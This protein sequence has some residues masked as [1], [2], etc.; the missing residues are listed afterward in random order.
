MKIVRKCPIC[1]AQPRIIPVQDYATGKIMGYYV[2]CQAGVD[3]KTHRIDTVTCKSLAKAIDIWN[4]EYY[5]GKV[6]KDG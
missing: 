5:E 4:G 6:Y 2:H 3:H 1:N